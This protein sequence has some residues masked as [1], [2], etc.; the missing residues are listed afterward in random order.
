M[1]PS[2]NSSSCWLKVRR[3]VRFGA[4]ADSTD[5]VPAG[6][7]EQRRVTRESP[8]T[9]SDEDEDDDG[10]GDGDGDEDDADE[11]D[12]RDATSVKDEDNVLMSQATIEQVSP[13]IKH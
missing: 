9:S 6:A 5:E 4:P 1:R 8:P 10:D 11:D 7:I 13:H 3:C 2:K 12:E